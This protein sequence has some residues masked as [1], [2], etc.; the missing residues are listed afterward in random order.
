MIGR[1]NPLHRHLLNILT[2]TGVKAP[3]STQRDINKGRLGKL[4]NRNIQDFTRQ[5]ITF[6]QNADQVY[7]LGI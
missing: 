6:R 2:G 3:T 5:R 7:Y 1:L 4:T